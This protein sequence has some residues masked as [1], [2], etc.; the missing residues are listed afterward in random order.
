MPHDIMGKYAVFLDRDD[1]LIENVPY[2]GDPKLVKLMPGASTAIADL[3]GANFL[4]IVISNQSGVGRGLITKEQVRSVDSRMEE[5]L[6]GKNIFATYEHCFAVPGDPYDDRRKPSP[7][8]I[9]QAASD[10]QIDLKRSFMIGNRLCDIQAGNSAGC[11][12]VLLSLRV[13][14]DEIKEAS[15]LASFVAS[16]W[17]KA[18]DWILEQ[19]SKLK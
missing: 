6:G 4:L 14:K 13:P 19:A 18:K 1:T 2:L 12:T 16:D 17:P 3:R 11:Q 9:Q 8:M 15:R 10:L 5:L 7:K